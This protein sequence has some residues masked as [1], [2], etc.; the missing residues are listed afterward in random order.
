MIKF[1]NTLKNNVQLGDKLT[2]QRGRNNY[3]TIKQTLNIKRLPCH[4]SQTGVDDAARIEK[5]YSAPPLL[6]SKSNKSKIL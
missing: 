6:L 3:G 2:V 4:K 1:T 5:H